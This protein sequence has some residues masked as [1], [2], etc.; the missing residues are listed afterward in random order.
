[1]TTVAIVLKDEDRNFI[2]EAVKS[3]RFGSE[4]EVIAE[5]LAEFRVREAI[6]RAKVDEL[7]SKVR[8]GIEQADRG[9]FIEFTAEDVKA[10][11]RRR[12]AAEKPSF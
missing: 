4:S 8:V 6:R 7:R 2:E 9:D 10:E 3:G 12:L 1:M 11:G 5:A